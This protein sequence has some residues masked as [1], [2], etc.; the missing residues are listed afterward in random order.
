MFSLGQT[1]IL[2][3]FWEIVY[4]PVALLAN[5]PIHCTQPWTQLPLGTWKK[6]IIAPS[7]LPLS[8]EKCLSLEK[9]S[10]KYYLIGFSQQSQRLEV[11]LF[12]FYK[13]GYYGSKRSHS[14]STWKNWNLRLKYLA[15]KLQLLHFPWHQ[16][17]NSKGER[18][19]LLVSNWDYTGQL[20]YHKLGH[21][22]NHS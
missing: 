5:Y 4:E 18:S 7:T 2:K 1:A 20:G 22:C 14:G 11:L 3:Q 21:E 13:I 6:K 16:A 9:H 17:G 12:L 15:A 8:T 19:C 10:L